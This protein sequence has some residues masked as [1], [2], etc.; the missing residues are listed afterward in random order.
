MATYGNLGCS[1]PFSLTKIM[2][3]ASTHH[4]PIFHVHVQY[5]SQNSC[6]LSKNLVFLFRPKIWTRFL[7]F[8]VTAATSRRLLLLLLLPSA[9]TH[10]ALSLLVL[11]WGEKPRSLRSK[12]HYVRYCK[13]NWRQIPQI[14]FWYILIIWS[15]QTQGKLIWFC[16]R[17]HLPSSPWELWKLSYVQ[18]GPEIRG[19]GS[20]VEFLPLEIL[21]EVWRSYFGCF[22]GLGF[23]LVFWSPVWSFGS[24]GN[25]KCITPSGLF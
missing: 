17:A 5:Q 10:R 3:S 7:A 6:L 19:E 20:F 9:A 15:K 22:C 4:K 25:A 12:S 14:W 1:F 2:R 8:W 21:W 23:S 16:T 11:G 13:N 24:S 18:S